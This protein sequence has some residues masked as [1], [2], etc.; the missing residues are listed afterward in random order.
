MAERSVVI[1]MRWGSS[2][3]Y[4]LEN[5]AKRFKLWLEKVYLQMEC[6]FEFWVG[7]NVLLSADV[8]YKSHHINIENT[9]KFRMVSTLYF[10]CILC[11]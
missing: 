5:L 10:L 7:A 6:C 4:V 11:R 2:I 3:C 9:S 8:R 1:V